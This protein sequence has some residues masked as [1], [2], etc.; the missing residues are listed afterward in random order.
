MRTARSLLA[1]AALSACLV[2]AAPAA[3]ATGAHNA[4]DPG[5]NHG[6]SSSSS[7]AASSDDSHWTGQKSDNGWTKGDGWDGREPHGGMHTGGGGMSLAGGGSLA[8]GSVLLLGGL[9]AG[10]FVL[11]RRRNGGTRAAVAV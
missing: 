3:H 5:S 11:R 7:S 10:A 8:A 1:G 6:A 4:Y 2:I 9:G